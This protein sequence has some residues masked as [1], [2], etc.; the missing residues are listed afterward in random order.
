MNGNR[1]GKETGYERKRA[2]KG[3]K[4]EQEEHGCGKKAGHDTIRTCNVEA[5]P[6]GLGGSIV[7][8]CW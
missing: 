2:K 7:S 8:G 5:T 4:L 1:I 6:P 3:N